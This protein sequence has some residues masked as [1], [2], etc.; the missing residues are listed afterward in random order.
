MLTPLHV[1]PVNDF[2]VKKNACGFVEMKK[3]TYT[4]GSDSK[5][6]QCKETGRMMR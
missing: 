6:K 3:L 4:K 1:C 5:A 2:K